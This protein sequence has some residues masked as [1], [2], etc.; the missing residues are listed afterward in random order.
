M[1]KISKNRDFFIVA[2]LFFGQKNTSNFRQIIVSLSGY[3]PV[4]PVCETQLQR[5]DDRASHLSIQ[6]R[7]ELCVLWLLYIHNSRGS[8]YLPTLTDS[9]R[10]FDDR[11]DIYLWW[12]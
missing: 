7:I 11:N 1:Q 12:G 10:L 5:R 2:C 9:E 8:K 3:F 6:E 4:F